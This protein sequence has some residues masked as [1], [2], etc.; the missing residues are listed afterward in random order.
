MVTIWQAKKDHSGALVRC[1]V[2]E[3]IQV[4]LPSEWNYPP[5]DAE[6]KEADSNRECALK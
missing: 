3:S 1:P 6:R 4:K 2:P 5:L